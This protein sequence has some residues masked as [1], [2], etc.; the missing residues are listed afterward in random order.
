MKIEF[1]TSKPIY[2]QVIDEIKRQIARGEIEP[3]GKLPSQ[4]ELAKEIEVNPNTVQRAYREMENQNLV[5]TK[6]G[7]GTFVKDDDKVIKDINQQLAHSA[8]KKFIDEMSAINYQQK[9]MIE[10]LK[11]ELEGRTYNEQNSN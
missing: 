9:E 4:R 10:L 5:E 7:R 8:V 1:N 11:N 3:N 6:R 2:E